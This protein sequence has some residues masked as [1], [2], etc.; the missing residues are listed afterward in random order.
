MNIKPS[1]ALKNEYTQISALA[2]ASGE[3][4]FITENGEADAVILSIAAYEE[5]E[6]ILALRASILEAEL[7]RLNGGTLHTIEE[8]QAM[9]EE[10]YKDD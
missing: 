2:K 3:P 6:K 4:I 7:D 8:A 5:R 10:I 1:T 9:L